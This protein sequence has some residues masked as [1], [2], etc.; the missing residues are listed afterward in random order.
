[1]HELHEASMNFDL[2]TLR[3]FLPRVERLVE[4]GF[5]LLEA[6]QVMNLAETLDVGAE[7]QLEFQVVYRGQ[8]VRIRVQVVMDDIEAPDVYFFT[9]EDLANAIGD[10]MIA[11]GE[12]LGV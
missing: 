4:S 1:M 3:A 10:E 11:F 9:S 2:D 5:G 6:G 12:D 7:G 8:W